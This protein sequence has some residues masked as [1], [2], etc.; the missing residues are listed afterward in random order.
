M[1]A[2]LAELGEVS[3]AFGRRSKVDRINAA[4]GAFTG[5]EVLRIRRQQRDARLRAQGK[6]RRAANRALYGRG[7][8]AWMANMSLA[9]GGPASMEAR[10]ALTSAMAQGSDEVAGNV[11]RHVGSLMPR[12]AKYTALG[13][14]AGIAGGATLAELSRR[15]FRRYDKYK[16]SPKRSAGWETVGKSGD[17][18]NI[19]QRELE[20]RN[21]RRAKRQGAKAFGY[22]AAGVG[23]SYLM[24][25][26]G[27]PQYALGNAKNAM[28]P[29]RWPGYTKFRTRLGAGGRE[30]ISSSNNMYPRNRLS[31]AL[32]LGGGA[33]ALGGAGHYLYGSAR[34]R[35]AERKI[36]QMRRERAQVRK[37]TQKERNQNRMLTGIGAGAALGGGL[38]VARGAQVYGR[39]EK[40][41]DNAFR[42]LS[43]QPQQKL[44]RMQ[45]ARRG[46]KHTPYSGRMLAGRG[47]SGAAI[48]G[49]LGLGGAVAATRHL[50]NRYRRS[51]GLP[52][53]ARYSR[54][55]PVEKGLFSLDEKTLAK[56]PERQRAHAKKRVRNAALI[57]AGAGFVVAPPIG[58]LIGAPIG[59]AWSK[60][61][62]KGE[63]RMN[64]R[65]A[66]ADRWE[67]EIQRGK[68]RENAGNDQLVT[69]GLLGGAGWAAGGT[70]IPRYAHMRYREAKDMGRQVRD[71]QFAFRPRGQRTLL[72][73]KGPSY[74]GVR[75][76]A[77][78]YA[79]HNAWKY[80]N[81][82]AKLGAAMLAG[83]AGLGAVGLSNVV[84]GRAAQGNARMAQ[85][86]PNGDV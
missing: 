70:V 6:S 74:L 49:A 4:E 55:Q 82:N 25:G 5:D 33:L 13:V 34:E 36:G 58:A 50:E 12:A 86:D 21:G 27:G 17:W 64:G 72:R 3:K 56:V 1:S 53:L 35:H 10:H 69:A 61:N 18:K 11:A 63:L 52:E 77:A 59:A 9:A 37:S 19:S 31:A 51:R 29:E 66:K 7:P 71:A 15:G 84:R 40:I 43:D 46:I 76:K 54:K 45:W 44:S 78:M 22:G 47:L 24:D 2:S 26:F 75:P 65:L 41:I 16:A 83:G 32:A 67:R 30:F 42:N 81:R 85:R 80:S 57:G 79:G 20:A 60:N 48:G 28:K 73:H 38:S 62:I 23:A 68:D 8:R 39:N 14:G